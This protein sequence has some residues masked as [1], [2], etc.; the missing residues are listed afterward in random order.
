MAARPY[1]RFSFFGATA[2]AAFA[3]AGCFSFGG[4]TPDFL[5]NL[6]STS[7]VEAGATRSG[8]ADTGLTVLTPE[9]PQRLS[10]TRVPVQA[11][12]VL[13]AYVEGAQ[14]VDTPQRL[15]RRLLSETIAAKTGRLVLDEGQTVTSPG[16]RL[17]GELIEFDVDAPALQVVVTYDASLVQGDNVEKRRFQATQ[18]IAAVEAN[19]VGV[20]LN[21]AANQVAADVAG[22]LSR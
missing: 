3:L 18:P 1:R 12:D 10:T 7:V 9:I 22:W 19:A 2:A 6:T 15:F 21:L 8:S 4:K 20:A 11:N 17:A 13:V 14:W 16:T 5:L